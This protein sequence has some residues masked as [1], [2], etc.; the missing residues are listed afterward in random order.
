MNKFVALFC[1]LALTSMTQVQARDELVL[2]TDF[3]LVTGKC[4]TDIGRMIEIGEI[5]WA[6]NATN[7]EIIA[8]IVEAV[9]GKQALA[10][11]KDVPYILEQIF[12]PPTTVEAF[13]ALSKKFLGLSAAAKDLTKLGENNIEL[14]A[15]FFLVTGQCFSDL[16]ES[17]E[18]VQVI[19]AD[20]SNIQ[21][22]V[23]VGAIIAI[24]GV[25]EYKMCKNVPYILQQIFRPPTN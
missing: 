22:D 21:Q 4:F 10:L 25:K 8:A 7:E 18:F 16:G 17:L 23:I 20:P 12:G 14:D 13:Q 6:S 11:C 19:L 2:S 1:L 24:F 3:F 9:E 15:D 5:A